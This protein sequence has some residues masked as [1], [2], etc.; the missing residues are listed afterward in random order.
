M[1]KNN[2][3]IVTVNNE[4]GYSFNRVNFNDSSSILNY[5]VD[6]LNEI[7]ERARV[8]AQMLEAQGEISNL[9]EET[10]RIARFNEQL[11]RGDTSKKYSK[12][13][14]GLAV[15]GFRKITS[16]VRDEEAT[17]GNFI[18]YKQYCDNL[19]KIASNVEED[20]NNTL[21]EMAI[22]S[23]FI[24]QMKPLMQKLQILIEVGYSDL[25]AFRT[26]DLAS[27]EKLYNANP[28][29]IDTKTSYF[30]GKQAS[31]IFE[32]QLVDL[33]KSLAL[34]KQTLLEIEMSQEP[35]MKLVVSYNSYLTTAA[36]NL[37]VQGSS[38]VGL[39]RQRE[40]I[41]KQRKLLDI[42]NQ[43]YVN[44]AEMLVENIED[45]VTLAETGN[46]SVETIRKVDEL[47]GK[48]VAIL[49][50]SLQK[51][52]ELRQGEI[53]ELKK[54]SGNVESY[55]EQIGNY[56]IGEAAAI[57]ALAGIDAPKTRKISRGKRR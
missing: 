19:K 12:G 38:M 53:D 50:E 7:Q 1:G 54:L 15:G 43:T 51:R 49:N 36:P 16:L 42:M 2:E 46:I 28:E 10:D 40:R 29:D 22:N 6:I 21:K 56:M 47:V 30:I 37:E 3:L 5:G 24:K 41:D 45:T 35:N 39:Q 23:D 14:I 4:E 18:K 57:E 8:H 32:T 34:Y 17:D 52:R 20:K 33:T 26:G 55:K 11:R 48:G 25:E 27:Y 13:L 44:N 31:D 9:D